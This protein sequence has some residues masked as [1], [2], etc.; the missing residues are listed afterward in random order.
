M[1][2][3][4]LILC[5]MLAIAASTVT[6]SAASLEQ[7]IEAIR[8]AEDPSGAVSAFAA[9]LAINDK[10]V[11]LHEAYLRRMVDLGAAGLAYDQ[12]K[13]LSEL[14]GSNPLAWG[15]MGF[16][17]AQ[18]GEMIDAVSAMDRATDRTSDDPFVLNTAGQLLAWYDEFAPGERRKVPDKSRDTLEVFRRNLGAKEAFKSG[19][20]TAKASLALPPSVGKI[21]QRLPP[22]PEYV[23]REPAPVEKVEINRY[24]VGVGYPVYPYPVY[25]YPVYSY[26]LYTNRSYLYPWY[27]Y[28]FP[29]V[30]V[31][32]S[33]R[34]H[35]RSFAL[36]GH[37]RTF[38]RHRGDRDGRPLRM[39][40]RRPEA[41]RRTLRASGLVVGPRRGRRRVLVVDRPRQ[42]VRSRGRRFA[43]MER[44]RTQNRNRAMRGG[45]SRP[46]RR[47]AMRGSR[48]RSGGQR[49]GGSRGGRR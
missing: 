25:S 26:P 3:K 21:P 46:G 5:A 24:E 10:S 32:G 16:V 29:S 36:F 6:A 31:V 30:I 40:G 1:K 12:A 48:M 9:G 7:Q 23:P 19:Y 4:L 42:R 44:T 41:V 11:L 35:F 27:G 8:K 15:V 14:D 45:R 34:D 17:L 49:G 37:R 39:R 13:T 2:N 20:E 28:H 47:G 22:A 33:R 18:R 43:Q 38:L